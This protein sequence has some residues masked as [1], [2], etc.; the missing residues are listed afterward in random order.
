LVEL[1]PA[2]TDLPA[3]YTLV[4]GA[5]PVDVVAVAAVSA[6]PDAAEKALQAE[7]LTGGYVAEYD[8]QQ[9]GAFVAVS[10]LRFAA[11]TGAR[12]HFARGVSESAADADAIIMP[13][14]GDESAAFTETVP[15]GDVAEIVS[16]RFRVRDVV[17]LIETGGQ[18]RVDTMFAQQIASRLVRRT[19]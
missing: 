7:G 8:E 4:E 15:E 16:V 5:G 3:G 12:A 13:A 9:T 14:V 2:V 1:V 10:V 6:D 19:V 18:Q 17:W 11:E